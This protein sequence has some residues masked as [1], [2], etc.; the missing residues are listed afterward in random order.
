MVLLIANIGYFLELWMILIYCG[1]IWKERVCFRKSSW[2]LFV[3][4]GIVL[5]GINLKWIP[6]LCV[7]LTYVAI[8]LYMYTVYKNR[9]RDTLVKFGISYALAWG[10]EIVAGFVVVFLTQYSDNE[11]LK[12]LLFNSLAVILAFW[13]TGIIRKQIKLSL[14]NVSYGTIFKAGCLI[15]I[16]IGMT[17]TTYYIAKRTKI[18]YDLFLV[19]LFLVLF[20]YLQKLQKS[21][22]EIEQ[23]ELALKMNDVY[24]KMYED[25]IQDMRRKQHDY[26][27]HLA[28]L[29]SSRKVTKSYE[30]L[31]AIQKEYYEALEEDTEY[32]DIMILCEEPILAGFLY[33]KCRKFKEQNVKVNYEIHISKWKGIVLLHEAIEILG[34]LLD[35][36]YEEVFEKNSEKIDLTVV[37]DEG[38]INVSVGNPIMKEQFISYNKLFEEGYS[39]K[40]ENRGLGLARAK[41]ICEKYNLDISVKKNRQP[42]DTITFTIIIP[43]Q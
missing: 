31:V 32:E 25:V 33:H 22:R 4:N 2:I 6:G 35:N 26:K 24:G 17:W 27:H 38:T 43:K 21:Q 18:W 8:F 1:C 40:G 11:Y 34:I 7:L 41:Q 28:A 39:T 9:L 12:Y 15:A 19:V 20:G 3:F 13:V 36:A 29:D 37:E 42:K 5:T 23:K 14:E 30:E 10:T 16:P